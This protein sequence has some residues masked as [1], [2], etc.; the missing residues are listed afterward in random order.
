MHDMTARFPAALWLSLPTYRNLL[1]SWQWALTYVQ[2][3]TDLDLS[4]LLSHAL[5]DYTIAGKDSRKPKMPLLEKLH[6]AVLLVDIVYIYMYIQIVYCMI[7]IL[8]PGVPTKH[9][10]CRMQS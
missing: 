10:S 5:P 7:L 9:A 2:R 3:A 6:T 4:N 1:E 8:D